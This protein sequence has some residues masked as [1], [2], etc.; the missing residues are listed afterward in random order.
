MLYLKIRMSK[1]N[2]LAKLRKIFSG[3]VW[4]FQ[5]SHQT[6][7]FLAVII[8]LMNIFTAQASDYEGIED[9]WVFL[10]LEN[11]QFISMINTISPYTVNID[12]DIEA[13]KT[14]I[15]LSAS[16]GY[17]DKNQSLITEASKLET[18]YLVQK[19]DTMSGIAKKFNMHVATII[20]RNGIAVDQ[21]ENLHPGQSLI[22]PPKDT[23]DS[24]EW[25]AQLNAKKEQERQLALKKQQEQ[26]KKL[27]QANRSVTYR[28]RADG[29][30]E[31]ETSGGWAQPINYRYIS[32]GIQRGHTG[33]DMIANVGTPIYASKSGKVIESTGG[34]GSGYGLSLLIDHGSDQTSRYA[35][36]SKFSVGVG[37]YVEQGQVIGYSG[38]TGWS[39]GPHLHFEARL[40]GRPFNPW[41]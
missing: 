27:A 4:V 9:H 8:I 3:N 18:E 34:W 39:T 31:G 12:E 22:I 14:E 24:R 11:D 26:K 7:F 41:R 29:N 10:E 35:H 23:S 20:E 16:D 6:I 25:L 17:L 32:R 36:M 38:N 1:L 21:I 30:Y 19:G 37:D 28:E 15:A 33:I 2:L 5:S 13:L 40:N